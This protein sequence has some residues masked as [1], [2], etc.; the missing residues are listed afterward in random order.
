MVDSAVRELHQ[1]LE[2]DSKLTEAR[3]ELGCLYVEQDKLDEAIKELGDEYGY[4]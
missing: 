3:V 4:E 1:A 2:L